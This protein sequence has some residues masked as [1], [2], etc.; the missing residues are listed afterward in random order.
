[1]PFIELSEKLVNLNLELDNFK[2][3]KQRKLIMN[4]IKITE[5][6]INQLV[7]E[8]YGLTDEEIKIIEENI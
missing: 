6:K 1:M 8:L 7:Y 3:P 5:D 4:Q 2:N